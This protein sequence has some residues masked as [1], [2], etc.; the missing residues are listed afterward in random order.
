MSSS[1]DIRPGAEYRAIVSF[2]KRRECL[3]NSLSRC[4]R[5]RQVEVVTERDSENAQGSR[6][7]QRGLVRPRDYSIG[8][9][10]PGGRN[11][12]RVDDLMRQMDTLL[13]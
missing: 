9:C 10:L 3:A 4:E 1:C 5:D 12:K 6:M 8:I 2:E 11:E 7:G 13:W